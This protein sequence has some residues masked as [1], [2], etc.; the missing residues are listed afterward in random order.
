MSRA[1]SDRALC[2]RLRNSESTL[3]MMGESLVDF[4]WGTTCSDMS[5]EKGSLV[6]VWRLVRGGRTLVAEK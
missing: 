3:D 5:A 2:A 1:R 4:N 6:A